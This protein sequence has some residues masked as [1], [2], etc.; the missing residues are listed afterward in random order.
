MKSLYR[1]FNDFLQIED[2]HLDIVRRNKDALIQHAD[3]FANVFYDYLFKFPVTSQLLTQ[4]QRTNGDIDALT[5]K[6]VEH[7]L[8]LINGTDEADYLEKQQHIGRI[9]YQRNIAPAWIM[10]A[11]RLYQ[12]HILS[13][14]ENSP[15]ID[16]HDRPTLSIS[17][18]KLLF[19]DM[20]MMLEGYWAAATEEI[21]SEKQ[22]VEELQRQISDLLTNIPQVIWSID[23][24]NNKPLYI[25]PSVDEISPISM[26][27]P[28]PCLTWTVKDD[29]ANVEKAWHKALKGEKVE[30]ESRVH[31]PDNNI[32]WFKRTFH[33]FTNQKGK[34]IRIDGIMEEITETK[35]ARNRLVRLA[36]TDILTG[37]ANRTLWYDR[38]TQAIAMAKRKPNKKVV[39]MQLDLNL[40]K[41]INDTLGHSA[42][43]VIL[44]QVARR[45][46]NSL[47][48]GDTLARMGGDEFGVLLPQEDNSHQAAET[49]ADK[50]QECFQHPYL[51]GGHKLY[52]GVS[53]G[54]A[55]YPDDSV[56]P[57]TLVRW[58]DIAM[59]TSKQNNSAYEYYTPELDEPSKRLHLISQM[60]QGLHNQEFELHFQPKINLQD[61]ETNGFE[62]LMRWHHP[63]QGYLM[64][65]T[66]IP[67]AE[68]MGL[69][70]ELTEWALADALKQSK[71]WH[72]LGIH[73]PVAVNLSPHSFQDKKFL[74]H[75]LTALDMAETTPE[76]LELEI[77]EN[78]LMANIESAANILRALSKI[79]VAIAIDDFGT[80]YSSLSYLKKLPIDQLKID[81]SFVIDMD[82]DEND[83]AIVRS[84]IDLGHNLGLKVVAEGVERQESISLLREL[85]CDSAQGFHIGKP[86][87]FQQLSTWFT[88]KIPDH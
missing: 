32:R 43:D 67:I 23:V 87:S 29:R 26:K 66:F 39:L 33:P 41:C 28:I 14:V 51:Y 38:V 10:G 7:L 47:R 45:L 63:Q 83:A 75:I 80:G 8:S 19:R 71:A 82:N 46:K 40:F 20:G 49:V 79:G 17:L 64:P 50:I 3:N 56:E 73:A 24:I 77:T 31:G 22:K 81:K 42:G 72:N 12:Q 37:L 74:K 36:T 58:A 5:R 2:S 44:R 4:Y 1:E 9:H 18:N 34:V 54:I 88:S 55:V 59:Y 86:M 6:Q 85:G 13:V 57:E 52:L 78:T 62:A 53:I 61:G 16:E 30:V 25:S 84:V 35:L 48:D 68:K 76:F 65:D 21:N 27:M 11:Y 60:K 15:T 69:I 70:H